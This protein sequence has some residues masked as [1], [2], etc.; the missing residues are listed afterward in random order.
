MPA[1]EARTEP[2][3][4]AP[5][6]R[7]RSSGGRR[8]TPTPAGPLGAVG[9]KRWLTESDPDTPL[10]FDWSHKKAG[11]SGARYG[12]YKAAAT[13]GEYL[14]LNGG[15]APGTMVRGLPYCQLASSD[16]MFDFKRGL[17]RLL[18]S[19]A[20]LSFSHPTRAAVLAVAVGDPD[21]G[22]GVPMAAAEL[23]ASFLDPEQRRRPAV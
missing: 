21:G 15:A 5:S 2:V 20:L 18:P 13:I 11:A 9:S 1:P 17:V 19:G 16:F 12:K 3:T 10:Y 7:A 8:S 22:L 4:V 6:P 14:R 23:A